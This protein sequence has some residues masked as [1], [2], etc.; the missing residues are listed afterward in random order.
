MT[1]SAI[2]LCATRSVVAIS[3]L[4]KNEPLIAYITDIYY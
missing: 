1:L 2:R 3:L 4:V